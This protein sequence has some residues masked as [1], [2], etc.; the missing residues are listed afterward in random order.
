MTQLFKIVKE[1]KASL[2]YCCQKGLK[3]MYF[4]KECLKYIFL[5]TLL[6]LTEFS[7]NEGS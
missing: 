4:W 3:K 6:V 7:Q 5:S 2:G 1:N